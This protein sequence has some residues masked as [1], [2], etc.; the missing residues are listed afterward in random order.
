MEIGLKGC[1]NLYTCFKHYWYMFGLYFMEFIHIYARKLLI[2][3]KCDKKQKCPN[4]NIMI[5]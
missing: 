1:M 2:G 3:K 4:T 5:L